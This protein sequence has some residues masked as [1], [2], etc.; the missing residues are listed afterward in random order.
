MTDHIDDHPH[1][2]VEPVSPGGDIGETGMLAANE[3]GEFR[4]LRADVWRQFRK[5]KGAMAGIVVL[6]VVTLACIFGPMLLPAEWL[7]I[8]YDPDQTNRGAGWPHILGTDNLG[9]DAFARA[10]L[11]G[12]IS[13]SVGFVAMIVSIV[14]GVLVGVLSGFFRLLDGPLMRLTDLF[15]SLPLLPVL[16]VV[17]VLFRDSAQDRFGMLLGTFVLMVTVIGITSWMQ[18]ARIVRGEVLAI[19]QQEFI[20]ASRSVGT[21]SRRIITK[22]IIPN[23]VS[24]VT[25]AATLGIAVAILTE[26]AVSFLGLGFSIENPTWGRLLNEAK[27]RLS[28]NI[29]LTIGPGFLLS[30]VVMSVNLIGDGLRDALD[31]KGRGNA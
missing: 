18:T 27:D 14:V 22:H 25:V 12:R 10:L 20:L 7:E 29:W 19:K 9:R 8:N 30:A 1:R 23:V 4:S 24:P 13:L 26:S 11:A 21:R 5:H 28:L 17:V 16:L 2:P 3:L 6:T 15:L 31:P